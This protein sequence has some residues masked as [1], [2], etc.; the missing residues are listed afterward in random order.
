MRK[1]M[2]KIGILWDLSDHAIQS[3]HMI[4]DDVNDL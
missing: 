1:K 2:Q 3:K 4:P